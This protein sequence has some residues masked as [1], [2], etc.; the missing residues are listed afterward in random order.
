MRN[1]FALLQAVIDLLKADNSQS[2]PAQSTLTPAQESESNMELLGYSAP[3]NAPP[4]VSRFEECRALS[5]TATQCCF[6]PII[7]VSVA[8]QTDN[9]PTTVASDNSSTCNGSSLVKTHASCTVP[10][11][12]WKISH[13]HNYSMS[14]PMVYPTYGL[15]E[16][17]L[18]PYTE[19]EVDPL[20]ENNI[21]NDLNDKE[22][23]DDDFDDEY[24]D[25]NW[26][27]PKGKKILLSDGNESSEGDSE[28][29][30][31]PSDADK[32]YL[33]FSNCLDQLLKRC[34]KC[35]VVVTSQKKKTTGS[36]LSVEMICLDGHITHWDSQPIIKRKP[37]GNLLLAASILFTG[38]TFA[39]VSRLASCLNLQFISESVFYDTQQR[40]LFPVLNQAWKNEQEIVRQELVNKGAINLNG[41][42]RCDSP[43]HSAKYG[44]YT[45]MDDD[46]GKVVA[47]SVVQV[48]E[49]TSSNAMEK[50]GFQRCIKSLQDDRVQIDRIATDRH[51]SISSFMNKEHPQI[52][53]QYDVWHLSK[54]VVKKLTSKAQQKGCE[55]L[56]PWIQSIS[57]HLWWCAATCDGNVVLL[58]EKWKSVLLHIVNKHKWTGN[59]LFHQCGHR[60]IP[61]SEAKNICWLKP[62]SPAHLA[63]EE[64]V[65]NT[66]LLKDLAKL[67]DFCHTGKIEVYHSMMLKYCSKQEHFSYKGMVARTQLAALDNNANAERPQA[68]VQSGEHA[69]QERYKACF[70]KAHKRWV[71]KPISQKKSYQYLSTLLAQVLERCEAGNAV[72]EPLP[73]VLPC[74]IAS[75]PAPAKEDLI[76][77]HRSR[78]NR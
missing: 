38:N 47:F 46:S 69:G 78:F 31:E 45:L 21:D 39:S 11:E 26:K 2:T 51:V 1:P 56:M 17:S 13:D 74:N 61:S 32:K 68:L 66:K 72:A 6:D 65:L 77:N 20:I 4:S 71:V 59:T 44:T 34:P 43:G 29:E 63:L 62:G 70:P 33:V 67:T 8:T 40:F 12:E 35:G 73:V 50:E 48:S 14:V 16:D 19:I 27:L 76:A 64:V 36:M 41:D 37:V 23:Y 49:V 10:A 53:H 5:D 52:N 18:T 24:K 42:G 28:G 25:P 22:V 3:H 30:L 57:N 7:L 58:R 60:R 9:L 15:D 75:E 54:W 55:E